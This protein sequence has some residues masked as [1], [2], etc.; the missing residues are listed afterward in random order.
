MCGQY[1]CLRPP[2]ATMT[3]ILPVTRWTFDPVDP[4]IY[5]KRA[6]RRVVCLVISSPAGV[7]KRRQ[8]SPKEPEEEGHLWA[9][10]ESS[11]FRHSPH[12]TSV[13]ANPSRH[14]PTT[15]ARAIDSSTLPG[16]PSDPIGRREGQ[17]RSID[18]AET[19]KKTRRPSTT[20]DPQLDSWRTRDCQGRPPRG[21]V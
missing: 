19:E 21:L 11:P 6:A 14:Q 13:S 8:S 10:E 9:E 1:A 18:N 15:R 20:D 3:E 16:R 4:S 12:Q 5:T 7:R 2:F 17:P